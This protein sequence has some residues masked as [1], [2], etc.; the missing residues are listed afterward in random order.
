LFYNLACFIKQ[1]LNHLRKPLIHQLLIQIPTLQKRVL[2]AALVKRVED[3]RVVA[4]MD[5][6]FAGIDDAGDG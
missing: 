2:D 1:I 4:A 5:V 6:V 3:A